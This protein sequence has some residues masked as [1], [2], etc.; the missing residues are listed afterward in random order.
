MNSNDA[1]TFTSRGYTLGDWIGSNAD[2]VYFSYIQ[3]LERGLSAGI[4]ASYSRE[5]GKEQPQ[6]QYELPYPP[7]LFG[8]RKNDLEISLN[9]KYEIINNLIGQVSFIHSNISDQDVS[10]TPAWML[11]SNEGYSVSLGYGL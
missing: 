1:Q 5:G 3:Y 11:G 7:F 9:F 10:R 6:Q 4:S 8:K 2:M